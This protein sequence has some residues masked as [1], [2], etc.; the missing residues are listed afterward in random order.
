MQQVLNQTIYEYDNLVQ[1]FFKNKSVVYYLMDFKEIKGKKHYLYDSV[2][3]F[4]IHH[5]DVPLL[6]NWREGKEGDWVLTDDNNV[7]QV[8]KCYDLKVNTSDKVSRC[9]RTVCGTFSIDRKNAR[10]LGSDGVA[11]NIYTFSGTYKA[12]KHYQKDGLKPKEFVFARYVA[13]GMGITQAYAKV[14]RKSNKTEYIHSSA[15]KLMKK[16]EV[17]TM[18]KEEIKKILQEEGVTPDWIVSRYKDIVEVAGKDSDKL[19]SLESLSKISGLFDTETKQEQLTVWSGFS[20]EQLE[21][22]KDGNKTEL[23]AHKKKKG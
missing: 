2:R 6:E 7:C 21:T 20:P 14:F 11:E 8:L 1:I 15:K 5:P 9:L 3:E 16:E 13:E 23:I 17:Q 22:I 18:V 19:R 12:F 4:R 10:I